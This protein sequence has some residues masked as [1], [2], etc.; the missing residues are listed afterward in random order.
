[1]KKIILEMPP[2]AYGDIIT[3]LLPWKTSNEQAAF[4]YAKAEDKNEELLFRFIE[5]ELVHPK[6]FAHHTDFYLELD[7][8]KRA[9]IIKRAHDLE[10]SLVEWHSHPLLWPAVF[11]VSDLLGFREFVPH[12][13]WRLK[14]RPYAAVVVSP[15]NF[16]ALAW[17][18]SPEDPCQVSFLKVGL[19]KMYPTGLT[20]QKRSLHAREV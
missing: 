9:Q 8:K 4:A 6:D 14:G 3:H 13:M 17:A 2:Q 16:D 5:W 19:R 15:S 11:S 10:A 12:V 20:L 18:D 7:E 1:M